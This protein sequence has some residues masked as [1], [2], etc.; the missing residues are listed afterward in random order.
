[1]QDQAEAEDYFGKALAVGDFNGDGVDDLAIGVPGEDSPFYSNI[2]GVHLLYGTR[3]NGLTAWGDLFHTYDTAGIAGQPGDNDAFG[4]ALAA[5]DFDADGEDDLA[6]GIPN[7]TVGG[8]ANAGRV[9]IMYSA[10]PNLKNHYFDQGD[11][12]DLGGSDEEENDH[13]GSALTAGDF[14][15]DWRDDLA[16]GVPDEDWG[17]VVD[18]GMVHVVYGSSGAGLSGTGD[19]F[20]HQTSTGIGLAEEASEFF[21][22]ALAAGDFNGDGCDDLAIGVPQ[23]NA[24]DPVVSHSGA[25]VVL[26]GSRNK[27]SGTNSQHWYQTKDGTHGNLEWDDNYGYALAASRA[28]Q[29]Y[30]HLPLILR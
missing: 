25:V 11:D 14:N 20:W 1:M 18:C 27:L 23:D 24:G 28:R 6:V 7:D 5:G 13:L 26:Y 16:I 15:G 22:F 4:S 12:G 29:S 9:T 21:G 17:T 8:I 3:A 10:S 19:Q 2:G 30:T